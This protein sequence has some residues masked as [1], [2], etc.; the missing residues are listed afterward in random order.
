MI[1]SGGSSAVSASGSSVELGERFPASPSTAIARTALSRGVLKRLI[2]LTL[3]RKSELML[4]RWAH[5][6]VEKAE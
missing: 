3:V 5:V 1:Y 4:A 2:L 6:D